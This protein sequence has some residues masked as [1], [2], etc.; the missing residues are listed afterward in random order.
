MCTAAVQATYRY[1]PSQKA[2]FVELFRESVRN[3]LE[4]IL[5]G[6]GAQRVTSFLQLNEDLHDPRKFYETFHSG[7]HPIFKES[8]VTLERAIALDLDRR[9]GLCHREDGEPFDFVK[10][11]V[12]VRE[13]LKDSGSSGGPRQHDRFNQSDWGGSNL[14]RKTTRVKVGGGLA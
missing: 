3:V 13:T 8:V 11:V 1:T 6:K 10:C 9:A 14:H 12:R 7:L 5:G 4:V 2:E